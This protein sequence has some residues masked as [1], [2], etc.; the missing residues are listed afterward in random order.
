MELYFPS[1]GK[2]WDT[3]DGRRAYNR[4]LNSLLGFIGDM[5][6]WGCGGLSTSCDWNSRP[7]PPMMHSVSLMKSFAMCVSSLRPLQSE[8][9]GQ[10]FP[11]VTRVGLLLQLF[12]S[13]EE[14]WATLCQW[15]SPWEKA[16]PQR[17]VSLLQYPEQHLFSPC[18]VWLAPFG[19]HL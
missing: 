2:I 8:G 16:E 5:M 7:D 6:H 11:L 13:G 19:S 3:I 9:T 10:P 4:S 17:G 18:L 15:I 12:L 14:N 1:S